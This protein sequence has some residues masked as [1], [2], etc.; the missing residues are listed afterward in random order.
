MQAI[1]L[2]DNKSVSTEPGI[3][4]NLYVYASVLKSF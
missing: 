4:P 3:T 2:D 1:R